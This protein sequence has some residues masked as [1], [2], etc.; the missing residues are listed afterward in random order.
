MLLLIKFC[1][2]PEFLAEIF[3]KHFWQIFCIISTQSIL[4]LEKKKIKN[5]FLKW[6]FVKFHQFYIF[7]LYFAFIPEFLARM[8]EFFQK[9]FWRIFRIIFTALTPLLE[10]INKNNF[11][12]WFFAKYY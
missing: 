7:F 3:Q 11:F 1:F 10:K 9:Q 8:A 6:F 5:M 12:K 4:L 2:T